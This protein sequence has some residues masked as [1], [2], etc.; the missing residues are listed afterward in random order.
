MKIN[1]IFADEM[2]KFT[3]TI[4]GPEFVKTQVFFIT[5]IFETCHI[6]DRRI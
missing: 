1:N 6:T 2:I 4:H 5:Q 3:S